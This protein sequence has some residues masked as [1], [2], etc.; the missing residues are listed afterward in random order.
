VEGTEPVWMFLERRE[1]IATANIATPYR[2]GTDYVARSL[3]GSGV[4]M[5]IVEHKR[6]YNKKR[7]E[8]PS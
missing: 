6:K 8:K 7:M 3:V 4:I 1:I 2:H 5:R